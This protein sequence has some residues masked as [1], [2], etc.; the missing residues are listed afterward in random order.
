[1]YPNLKLCKFAKTKG[2][3]PPHYNTLLINSDTEFTPQEAC[4]LVDFYNK[5][6]ICHF[7][8]A[9]PTQGICIYECQGTALEATNVGYISGTRGFYYAIQDADNPHRIL[10]LA[11]RPP[12]NIIKI[13][14]YEQP[15]VID[16]NPPPHDFISGIYELGSKFKLIKSLNP[17]PFENYLEDLMF[18]KGY[19]YY[20]Q[21][22]R[23]YVIVNIEPR[24]YKNPKNLYIEELYYFGKKL[25]TQDGDVISKVS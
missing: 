5:R 23:L 1:M 12:S 16:L 19:I 18:F 14:D 2:V 24:P 22:G 15:M 20:I 13:Y 25:I 7:I 8:A 21:N 3:Y 6:G 17:F 10:A 9:H 11:R 4:E